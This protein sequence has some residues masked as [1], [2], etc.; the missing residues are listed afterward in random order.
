MASRGSV[1]TRMK[2]FLT[3]ELELFVRRC[4][5]LIHIM[6]AT[7][8]YKYVLRECLPGQYAIGTLITLYGVGV[9]KLLPGAQSARGIAK[10]LAIAG[11]LMA[12]TT[13]KHK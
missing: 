2:G 4:G 10:W 1:Q 5:M 3:D 13:S 8:V 12:E 7:V 11:Q 9:I 6:L